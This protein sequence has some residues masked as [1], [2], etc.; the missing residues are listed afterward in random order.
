MKNRKQSAAEIKNGETIPLSA[1]PVLRYGEFAE[2]NSS[3]ASGEG[4]HCSHMFAA[5]HEKGQR[6][7]CIMAD[8]TNGTLLV[9]S[10]VPGRGEV[11]KSL[12]AMHPS[13]HPFER[14]MAETPGIKYADHPWPKPLRYPESPTGEKHRMEDYP[15]FQIKGEDLHEVGVG[16]IHAGVIEPGHFRFICN[17][18]KVLHLEIQLGYQHRGAEELLVSK[19]GMMEKVMLAE[20]AAG[21]TTAGNASAFAL[22]Y[23][24]LAG[25]KPDSHVS[26]CRTLALELERMAIHTGDL[27]ALSGDVAYQLGNAV[28]GR[29]RTPIINY[30]QS[31]SGNRLGRGQIRP[32]RVNFPFTE[33]LALSLEKMLAEYSRDYIEMADTLFHMPGVQARFHKTGRLT[34]DDALSMGLVGMPARSTGIRRDI[35]ATHPHDHYTLVR[36]EPVLLPWGDVQARAQL[37]DL[38]IRQSMEMVSGMIKNI[39]PQGRQADLDGKK[40]KSSSLCVSL[41]E[42]WRGEICHAAIT[43]RK[44]EIS[45]YRIKDPSMHNWFGLAMALRGQEISDFPLCNKSFNLSYCGHDL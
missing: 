36:H 42:G 15:F 4:F 39:P 33:K 28:F 35:R 26:Y 14:A 31:W 2:M 17:G 21:D 6:I 43:D 30:T 3:L 25:A 34:K 10:A 1:V 27:A 24:S 13:F 11:L 9:S 38:E 12:T 5:E 45:C 8:D 16:P 22:V 23:E 20:S 37:R 41:V 19:K 18:E 44:G 29:L 40:L 32:G 7:F